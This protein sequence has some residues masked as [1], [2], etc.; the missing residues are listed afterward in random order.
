MA[1]TAHSKHAVAPVVFTYLPCMHCSQSASPD[2]AVYVPAEHSTHSPE[3]DASAAVPMLQSAT[4]PER[5][6]L[7]SDVKMTCK[8]P[9]D[10][11]CTV[12]VLTELPSRRANLVAEL[13]EASWHWLMV[14]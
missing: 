5:V 14:T 9:V 13:H 3:R 8:Y 2:T 1:F 12:L 6:T 4:K 7:L 11:K 10:D